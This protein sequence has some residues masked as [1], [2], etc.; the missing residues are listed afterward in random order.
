VLKE[1]MQVRSERTA[2]TQ[3][4]VLAGIVEVIE[5]CRQVAPVLD[6]GS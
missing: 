3:D 6:R 4:Y 1:A 5:R 2:I